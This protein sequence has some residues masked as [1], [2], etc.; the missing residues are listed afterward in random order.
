MRALVA[1]LVLV[2]AC[3]RVAGDGTD[4]AT[5]ARSA[6]PTREVREACESAAAVAGR[7]AG[8]EVRVVPDTLFAYLAAG[9]LPSQSATNDRGCAV[10][11]RHYPTTSDTTGRLFRN[12]FPGATWTLNE[13]EAVNPDSAYAVWREGAFC[14][15]VAR[16][17]TT[18]P[19]RAALDFDID[20]HT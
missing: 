1:F 8:A 15:V 7:P 9:R 20:C 16:Q 4:T 18:G 13:F 2:A 17:D 3:R 19:A 6:S 10:I 14:E 11:V 5:T 12:G